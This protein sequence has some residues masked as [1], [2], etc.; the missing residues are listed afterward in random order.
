MPKVSL[1]QQFEEV[2]REIKLREGVYPRQVSSGKM[3]QSVADYHLERMRAVA[4]TLRWL[5]LNEEKIKKI[6]GEAEAA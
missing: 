1:A 4:K 3:R 6:V 5:I 2:E